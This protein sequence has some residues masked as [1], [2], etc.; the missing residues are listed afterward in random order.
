MAR[1]SDLP[2]EILQEIF[3]QVEPDDI[4]SLALGSRYI[5]AAS[6][7]ALEE[8]RILKRQYTEI[9]HTARV[10]PGEERNLSSDRQ[11]PELLKIVINNPRVGLYI[12]KL[13]VE[14]CEE[15][16]KDDVNAPW[17]NG[18]DMVHIRYSPDDIDLFL[19]SFRTLPEL[20]TFDPLPD[21]IQFWNEL[22]KTGNDAAV[23][24]LLMMHCPNLS[25]LDYADRGTDVIPIMSAF[26]LMSRCP[27]SKSLRRLK[28]LR[29]DHSSWPTGT[30]STFAINLTRSLLN[31]PS[32][33]SIHGINIDSAQHSEVGGPWPR[34][35][36]KLKDVSFHSCRISDKSLHELL[37]ATIQLRSF[38]CTQATLDPYWIRAALQSSARHSLECLKL[39]NTSDRRRKAKYMGSLKLFTVLRTVEVDQHHLATRNTRFEDNLPLSLQSL[40]MHH[41]T[42]FEHTLRMLIDANAERRVLPHVQK[43]A[44]NLGRKRIE[45]KKDVIETL[46]QGFR[47]QGICVSFSAGK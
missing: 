34:Q 18:Q 10:N 30:G 15:D 43:I 32:L 37:E 4:E 20:S 41:L 8:H 26:D 17:I 44:I 42:E 28:H 46:T 25:T 38:S 16:V 21:M 33:E 36:S 24:A 39:R 23:F 5:Y 1:L 19:D 3:C 7:Q 14:G 12:K 11:L 31:L 2:T 9:H 13:I 22:F 27:D 45:R 47:E 29:F 40:T 6:S 35:S